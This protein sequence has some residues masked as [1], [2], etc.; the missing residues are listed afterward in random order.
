MSNVAITLFFIF[1][2]K[3]VDAEESTEKRLLLHSQDDLA[4]QLIKMEAELEA[5]R[6]ISKQAGKFCVI[7]KSQFGVD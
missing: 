3:T 4:Q 5:L 2:L 6:N 1:I 7:F